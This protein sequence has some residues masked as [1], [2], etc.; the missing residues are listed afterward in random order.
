MSSTK[1]TMDAGS[2][3]IGPRARGEDHSPRHRRASGEVNPFA[4]RRAVRPAERRKRTTVAYVRARVFALLSERYGADWADV[5]AHHL[6]SGGDF[7]P[8]LLFT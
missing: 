2:V 6:D 5:L 7:Y 4:P 1:H 8:T 3:W